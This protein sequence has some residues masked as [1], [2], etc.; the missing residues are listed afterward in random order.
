MEL[1]KDVKEDLELVHPKLFKIVFFNDDYTTMDFV[2]LLLVQVFH[3]SSTQ[4]QSIMLSIHKNG[5]EVVGIYPYDI[6]E[7]KLE[8][9]REKARLNNFPLKIE[10]EE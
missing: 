4:A 3:K 9:A 6:A 8:M 7:T 1:K 2:V 5:K 10:I